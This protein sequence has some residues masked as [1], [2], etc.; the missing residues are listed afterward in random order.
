[1][2]AAS[3]VVAPAGTDDPASSMMWAM[4]D[5]E[6]PRPG[7]GDVVE[8]VIDDHRT[9]EAL[10]RQLRDATSDREAARSALADLLV[11]HAEAEESTVYRSL[12]RKDAITADDAEHGEHEHAEGHE[13][14]LALL[15]CGATD[16]QQFDDAV[17]DLSTA[18]MHHINEEEQTILNP[19]RTEVGEDARNAIGRDFAAARNDLLASS[20]GALGNVRELVRRAHAD[21]L[22]DETAE[23]GDERAED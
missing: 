22:L 3:L 21:G 17:E 11:A 9:F 15:E 19:A 7:S 13:A 5:I 2:S 14:L 6:I 4:T 12:K 16:T 23:D 18:L 20:P 8:L 1:M 10:L